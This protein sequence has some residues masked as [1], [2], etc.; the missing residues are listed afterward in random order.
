MISKFRRANLGHWKGGELPLLEFPL[1]ELQGRA[2]KIHD[3]TT[4][5]WVG[6][7][8]DI[9][10]MRPDNRKRAGKNIASENGVDAAG[11][12]ICLQLTRRRNQ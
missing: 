9:G 12:Y 5:V 6:N 4:V 8:R 3:P 7:D 11:W 2:S 10:L 1:F